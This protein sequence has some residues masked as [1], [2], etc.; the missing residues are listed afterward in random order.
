M[1]KFTDLIVWQEAHRLVLETYKLTKEFPREEIFALTDQMRR[2]SVS[3]VSNIAE[4][5]G[6]WKPKD[7]GHFYQQAHGS[8]TE[9]KSQILI[10]RDLGYISKEQSSMLM[11]QSDKTHILLQGL[12]KSMRQRTVT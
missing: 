8:L 9:L 12:M 11:E 5:F 7:K 1:E 3:I 4:G 6:R 10:A 2:A